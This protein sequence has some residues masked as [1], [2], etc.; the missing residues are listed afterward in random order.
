MLNINYSGRMKENEKKKKRRKNEMGSGSQT[1]FW[2]CSWRIRLSADFIC[3]QIK[4]ISL[5]GKLQSMQAGAPF[6]P[7]EIIET[8][9]QLETYFVNWFLG[10]FNSLKTKAYGSF[11]IKWFLFLPN[12]TKKEKEKLHCRL[13]SWEILRTILW[14]WIFLNG[15]LAKEPIIVYL[16]IHKCPPPFGFNV[17]REW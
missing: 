9:I 12:K 15:K 1:F 3:K 5:E 17:T 7:L 14:I 2:S 16:R 6:Q 11:I 4:I 13:W 10:I 8:N